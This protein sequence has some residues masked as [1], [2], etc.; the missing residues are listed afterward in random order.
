MEIFL[1]EADRDS[2]PTRLWCFPGTPANVFITEMEAWVGT[3]EVVNADF[4]DRCFGG[5]E[6]E[7]W[8]ASWLRG[9]H[10]EIVVFDKFAEAFQV[11]APVVVGISY[12]SVAIGMST[13]DSVEVREV[14]R[15]RKS[16]YSEY[17]TG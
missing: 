13:A 16:G 1:E 4:V 12:V 7:E 9:G 17:H 3:P 5:I 15:I 6:C 11:L 14:A 8:S 10:A 2:V